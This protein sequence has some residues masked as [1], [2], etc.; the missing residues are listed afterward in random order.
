M[1]EIDEYDHQQGGAEEKETAAG[2]GESEAIDNG[3]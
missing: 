1:L 2:D 3:G